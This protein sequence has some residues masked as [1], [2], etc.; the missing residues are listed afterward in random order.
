VAAP[1]NIIIDY[2]P[3]GFDAQ[4]V[5]ATE[6]KTVAHLD[7]LLATEMNKRTQDQIANDPFWSRFRTMRQGYAAEILGEVVSILS[8]PPS[9]E[10]AVPFTEEQQ[11]WLREHPLTT[12][13]N[14]RKP[15]GADMIDK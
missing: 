1:T 14:W 15:G 13:M 2:K 5:L 12:W 4:E 3:P 6:P 8:S 10:A 7:E 11:E 9:E